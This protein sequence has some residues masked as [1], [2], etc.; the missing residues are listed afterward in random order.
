MNF[1]PRAL[2]RKALSL[3]PVAV[4]A[5]TA[6]VIQQNE[7]KKAHCDNFITDL[8][9]GSATDKCKQ[10]IIKIIDDEAE[11]RADGTSI[12]PTFIRLAWHQSGTYSAADGTG[13][14]NGSHMRMTP[15]S[16]WGCNAGLGPAREALNA[17]AKKHNMSHADIWT[18]A[19]AT[20]VEAMGG[21]HIN[22][23]RGRTDSDKPT[24]VPDGRLPNADN[25]SRKKDGA[26]SCNFW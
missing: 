5:S 11:R 8:I 18:L 4:L 25:G 2:S 14:S 26:Y 17:L 10:D 19:G 7:Q 15:E 12:A 1:I 9:F 20:A 21:P 13:G 16:V 24:T 22:W 23:H 3:A 6:F